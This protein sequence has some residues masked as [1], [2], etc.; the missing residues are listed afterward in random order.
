MTVK[1]Q[2]NSF[3]N[4][5]NEDLN[6][7][8]VIGDYVNESK[9]VK[10]FHEKCGKS[11]SVRPKYFREIKMCIKCVATPNPSQSEYQERVNI[12]S[13]REYKVI[14][15]YNG[16]NEKVLKRHKVCGFEWRFLLRT[17]SSVKGVLN[18]LE[19][20]VRLRNTS[21]KKYGRRSETNTK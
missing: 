13:N 11:F 15:E 21:V 2:E 20:F 12:L 10:I 5:V 7:F 16:E 3:T 9:E 1:T 19:G 4:F 18:V 8:K 14:S 17:S 6:G